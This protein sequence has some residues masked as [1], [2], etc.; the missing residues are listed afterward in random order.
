MKP[1]H[2][3]FGNDKESHANK[4]EYNLDYQINAHE[5]LKEKMVISGKQTVVYEFIDSTWSIK[6]L[7]SKVNIIF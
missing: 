5:C 2:I 1:G 3:I 6:I 4:W 7:S